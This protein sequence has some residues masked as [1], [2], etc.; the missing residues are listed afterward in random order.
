[1]KPPK[2]DLA[3]KQVKESMDKKYSPNWCCIIGLS[4]LLNA[5]TRT[6]C[7]HLFSTLCWL[8]FDQTVEIKSIMGARGGGGL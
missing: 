7:T 8:H 3:A 1:M 5:L 6:L 4:P 2:Y